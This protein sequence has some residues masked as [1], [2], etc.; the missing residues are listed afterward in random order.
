MKNRAYRAT[1]VKHVKAS[2]VVAAMAPGQAW[3]GA[4]VAK[5]EVLI[6]VRDSRGEYQRPWRVKQPGELRL[7]AALLAEVHRQRPSIVA[8]ESTGTYGDALRQALTDAGLEVQRVS[9]KATSDYAEIFDGVPSAHDGK[10]AAILAELGAIGKSRPWPSG[11]TSDWE[12]SLE[13]GV[14]WLDAQQGIFQGWLGRLEALLARHWPESARN[15]ELNS[16]TLLHALAEY[17]GPAGLAQAPDAAQ[18]LAAWG[19][20][21]LSQA[22]I[23]ALLDSARATVGVRQTPATIAAI[24][25]MAAEA[26]RTR[27]QIAAAQLELQNLARQDQATQ[28]LAAAVGV[29]TACVLRAAL[30]DPHD[31]H[32]AA[33]YR[34]AMGLNLKEHSS[35]KYQGQLKITKR[36]S[37]QARRWMF[38]AA[39]RVAQQQPVRTWFEAKKNKDQG[40]GLKAVVAVMRKLALALHG[41]ATRGV[42]LEP[43]RL[44]PGRPLPRIAP[45]DAA[46]LGALP[47]DPRNLSLS[48][49]SRTKNK[50]AA[51]PRDQPPARSVL[52]P[53]TALGSVST[54]ALS[55]ARATPSLA[56][57][58]TARKRAARLERDEF[59]N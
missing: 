32:C 43:A 33:A 44:F 40:R 50:R 21:F 37:S 31:Y 27:Q 24:R 38:F 42:P 29:G 9:G 8:L 12:A 11:K 14:A 36:G 34:K 53:E 51:G 1:E 28:R 30:G 5:H 57:S 58:T 39:L 46:T 2:E 35:G 45:S 55:S 19:G 13:A 47:P 3:V 18:Q 54:G 25:R 56:Q 41:V 4:D 26:L 22:K 16:A 48:G 23:D 10:D 20:R 17:G 59:D 15:L 52:A 6:V 7:L 49:Q